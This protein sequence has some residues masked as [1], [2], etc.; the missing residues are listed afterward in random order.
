MAKIDKLTGL[1]EMSP[2][3]IKENEDQLTQAEG[4]LKGID[5][6]EKS[7]VDMGPLKDQLKGTIQLGKTIRD[8]NKSVKPPTK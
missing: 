6:I 4:L 1:F 7:G 8:F 2:E 3:E 5:L